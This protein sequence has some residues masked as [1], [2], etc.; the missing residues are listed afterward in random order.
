MI[1]LRILLLAGALSFAG[2]IVPATTA[3]AVSMHGCVWPQV[4]LYDG[5]Y[6]TGSIFWRAQQTIWQTTPTNRTDA[7]VNTRNDDSVW[8]IDRTPSPDHYICIPRNTAVNLGD[9]SHGSYGTWANDIDAM[10]IWGD[11]DTGTCSGTYNVRVGT[12][13]DR[14]Y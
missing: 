5:S 10:K 7:V 13:P 9:F 2:L 11:P 4:C 14:S 1:K 6:Q 3:Q 8:L 12:T